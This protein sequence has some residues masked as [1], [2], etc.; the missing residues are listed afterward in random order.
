MAGLCSVMKTMWSDECN[1]CTENVSSFI[2]KTFPSSLYW[3]SAPA[4]RLI[5]DTVNSSYTLSD[6]SCSVNSI[7]KANLYMFRYLHEWTFLPTC[8]PF[9]ELSLIVVGG[10]KGE[11][12]NLIS[13]QILKMHSWWKR[14]WK[15][16]HQLSEIYWHRTLNYL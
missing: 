4:I 13:Q 5:H 7:F 9:S 8:M 14:H 3:T 10:R 2:K 11:G 16:N 6:Y 12:R 1:H 15:P